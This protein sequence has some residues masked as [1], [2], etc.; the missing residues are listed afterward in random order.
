MRAVPPNENCRSI[1]TVSMKPFVL[2]NP[3]MPHL[4]CHRFAAAILLGICS[5]AAHASLGGD[6]LSI[7]SDSI[8]INGIITS[9]VDASYEVRQIDTPGGLR[10]RE[11]LTAG[12]VFGIA[13]TGPVMPDMQKLLGDS[14]AAYARGLAA[15]P[16][17]GLQRSIRIA[18]EGL[19]VESSGHMRAY[20]GR[21]CLP[22]LIPSGASAAQVR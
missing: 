21:A 17:P 2:H 7:L 15:L 16:H 5:A 4:S 6:A 12:R 1:S 8:E 11:Y 3:V 18:S 13:W 9:N 20:S 14:F 19:I 10:I 22:A